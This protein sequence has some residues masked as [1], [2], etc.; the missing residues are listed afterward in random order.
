M[1]K[2]GSYDVAVIGGGLAGLSLSISLAQ[3][4]YRILLLEKETYPFHRVC[5]EYISM[6]S[7][8]F[9]ERLGLPLDTMDLPLIHTLTV[10]APDGFLVTHP[11][12]L[13]GFG[14]SRYTLDAMLAERARAV[15]VDLQT[16]NRINRV[17]FTG[18]GFELGSNGGVFRAK[19]A[20]GSFGK[21]SNLDIGMQRPFT[22]KQG[23]KENNY[24]GIKYHIRI[25]LP[26]GHI[27]LH[28]FSDGYCGVSEVD[29]GVH[30]LCYLTTAAN[31]AKSGGSIP[32]MEKEILQQNPHLENIF[33]R[34]EFLW[35]KPETIARISFQRKAAVEQHLLMTGDAAGMISPLCGNGM[36]MAF[37]SGVHALEAIDPFLRGTITRE[38]MEEGYQRAWKKHFASRMEAGRIIQ[39]F[40]G[41]PGPTKLFLQ[42][43]KP[44]PRFIEQIIRRTHGKT[45]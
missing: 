38:E 32:R 18:D 36:S 42:I 33:N 24:V 10:S 45:F 12:S 16:G 27:A 3:K 25:P 31:L 30:C 29:G 8:P 21:R 44:F 4:G 20:V 17:T 37:R 7:R 15:G 19:V 23:G 26:K 13:G 43:L 2:T 22:Q 34:A 28:N 11:L 6:E 1:S 14:I 40:F 9:L 5:G 39:S 41:K 35:T